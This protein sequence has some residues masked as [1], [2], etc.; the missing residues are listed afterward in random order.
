MQLRLVS[1]IVSFL[2]KNS[3]ILMV[4]SILAMLGLAIYGAIILAQATMLSF[5]IYVVLVLVVLTFAAW[6]VRPLYRL[7]LLQRFDDNKDNQ[8]SL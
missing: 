1:D 5:V 2:D 4:I 6:M 7:I 3:L 8:E